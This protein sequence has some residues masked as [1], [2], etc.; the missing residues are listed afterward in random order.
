LGAK[1]GGAPYLPSVLR[2][3]FWGALAMVVTAVVGRA[4]GAAVG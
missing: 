4:F 3:G 1:A 2:V